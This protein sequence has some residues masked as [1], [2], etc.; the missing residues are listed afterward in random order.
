MTQAL[1]LSRMIGALTLAG[2]LLPVTAQTP[3]PAAAAAAQRSDAV[4]FLE[5]CKQVRG[6]GR[7]DPAC[8]GTAYQNQ[9]ERL[10]VEAQRTQDPALLSLVGDAYSNA[11]TP[12]TG[13][14]YQW[15][16][17]AAVRGD[18]YAMTRLADMY[19][20]GQGVP[21][22]RIKAFGYARA[23]TR[24]ALPGSAAARHSEQVL[25]DLSRKMSAQEIAL[26]ERFAT[27]LQQDSGLQAP[28]PAQ[29][30]APSGVPPRDLGS[31]DSGWTGPLITPVP[32]GE[33]AG[34]VL[35]GV[36]NLRVLPAA[37]AASEARTS[38]DTGGAAP[39]VIRI[40]AVPVQPPASA[41]PGENAPQ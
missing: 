25:A 5:S 41:P 37:S 34:N 39:G 28:L 9:L 16:L 1:T 14:A 40:P 32:R 35:P 36:G 11:R 21:Q 31:I 29:G 13:D 38:T 12:F 2:M 26:A 19:N 24:L 33:T 6:S 15:Y 27:Q 30:A 10:R 7:I 23:S 3:A 8:E 17:M 18:P 20:S 22:D 4:R